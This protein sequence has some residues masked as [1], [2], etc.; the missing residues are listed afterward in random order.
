MNKARGAFPSIAANRT[1]IGFAV[2]ILA[3]V[4]WVA[5]RFAGLGYLPQPFHYKPDETL[6]DLYKPAWWSHHVGGYDFWREIYPPLSPVFLRLFSLP[7]CYQAP[8]PNGWIVARGCDWPLRAMLGVFFLANG[9]LAWLAFRRAGLSRAWPRAT[10]LCLGLPMLYAL[11]RGNLLIPCFTC[12]LLAEG[13]IL[14]WPAARWLAMGLA[15]NFKPYLLVVALGRLA[16]RQWA[17]LAG[18]GVAGLAIYLVT[19]ALEGDGTPIQLVRNVIGYGQNRTDGPHYWASFYYA[20]SYLPL[21]HMAAAGFS[22]TGRLGAGGAET[23]RLA[24]FALI[25]LAQL[26]G[27]ACMVV[28][29]VRPARVQVLRFAALLAGLALT[30]VTTG[31]AGYAEVFV[32]F[33]VFLEPWRG[34]LRPLMLLAAYLLCVPFDIAIWPVRI[35]AARSFLSGRLVDPQFGVSIGQLVRPG[36]ML[37]IQFCLTGLNLQDMI[38]RRSQS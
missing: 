2:V 3:A 20:A 34:R 31:S 12:L 21:A 11:D 32:I 26:G 19:L 7:G 33:L 18:V 27:F 14:A 4:V 5:W 25:R 1:E 24:I 37:V 29:C 15:L 9:P 16:R 38:G 13:D 28:A 8:W 6:N 22:F 35:D 17:W 23:L 30:T 10:T 36:L